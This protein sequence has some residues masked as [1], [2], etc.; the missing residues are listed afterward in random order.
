[1]AD[2]LTFEDIWR[3]L[4][5]VEGWLS[6][7]QARML[8]EAAKDV[9]PPGSV[10]EIGSFRGRS[11]IVL[12]SSAAEGVQVVAIDPHAGT[13]RGPREMTTSAETGETDHEAFVRNLTEA[14]VVERID[15]IRAFS[16]RAHDE[17]DGD[18]DVLF[19]DGAH[20]Y[21][22]ARADIVEWGGRVKPGGL[23][24]IHDS[25]NSVGVTLAQLR[26]LLLAAG[27]VFEGRSRSL[28]Q[29]RKVDLQLTARAR[30]AGRQ[31]GQLGYFVRSVAIKAALSAG[32]DGLARRLGHTGDAPW[33]Y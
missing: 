7:G 15:H 4:D 9:S 31:L 27:W 21:A 25:F 13:D 24:L 1:M 17:V 28:S 29:Y 14:G 6:E 20:R 8:H 16:D 3:R 18:I 11:A 5:G 26:E 2:R 33:P 32:R 19:I 22:P 12:G 30:N 23:M 10:V